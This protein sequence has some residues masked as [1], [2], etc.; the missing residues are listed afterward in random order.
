MVNWP[1]FVAFSNGKVQV[2]RDVIK[3]HGY[4]TL[5]RLDIWLLGERAKGEGERWGWTK[6]CIQ[7]KSRSA[8]GLNCCPDFSHTSGLSRFNVSPVKA[9]EHIQSSWPELCVGH[10]NR[11]C[12]FLPML[13]LSCLVFGGHIQELPKETMIVYQRGA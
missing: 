11:R 10:S 2:R 6:V 7:A 3:Q 9:A 1:I 5:P 13:C 4:L 8:A 12:V